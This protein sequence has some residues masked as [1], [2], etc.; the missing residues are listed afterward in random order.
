MNYLNNINNI[1][2]I[3]NNSKFFS[4]IMMIVLNLGSR[5]L[6]NELSETQEQ[7]ISNKIIRRFI[8]FT[9]VF[10]ATKDIFIS[11][12]ITGIFIILVS[13]LFNENSKFCL[14]T[15]PKIK[16]ITFDDYNHARKII[17]LYE[18]QKKTKLNI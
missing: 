13:G 16:E 14:I 10:V 15:K 17:K 2:S 5:F 18:L 4:G 1:F 7:L 8:I 9:I 6:I 12:V 11:L 3:L